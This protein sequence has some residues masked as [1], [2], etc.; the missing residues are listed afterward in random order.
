MIKTVKIIAAAVIFTIINVGAVIYLNNYF[1]KED[2]KSPSEPLPIKE[3]SFRG[4]EGVILAAALDQAIRESRMRDTATMYQIMRIQHK[5]KMHDQKIP[6][7]PDCTM[8]QNVERERF[9]Q[10]KGVEND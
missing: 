3:T 1:I 9:V 4:Q 7:C 10:N 8:R 6:L 2:K 5:L